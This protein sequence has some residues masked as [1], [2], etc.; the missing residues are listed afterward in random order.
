MLSSIIINRANAV[1]HKY[2]RY[3]EVGFKL[4]VSHSKIFLKLIIEI[5]IYIYIYVMFEL[6]DYFLIIYE[7]MHYSKKK[8][9]SRNGDLLLT[10]RLVIMYSSK[11]ISALIQS[12]CHHCS[13]FIDRDYALL[14][15]KL[16]HFELRQADP[17]HDLT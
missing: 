11:H 7:K 5:Y 13:I 17:H 3:H 8:F 15:Y 2:Y 4:Y 12:S 6:I 10:F 9:L 16:R 14:V 1:V